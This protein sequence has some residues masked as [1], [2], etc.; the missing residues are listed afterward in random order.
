MKDLD[1]AAVLT[2]LALTVSGIAFLVSP[3]SRVL[4]NPDRLSTKIL[5]QATLWTILAG[6]IAIVVFW[7]RQ[8]IAS[9][10]LR[11]FHWR[12][13]AFGLVLAAFG[14]YVIFPIR[15]W[16]L[17]ASGLPGFGEGVETFL[18]LPLWFRIVA[19]TTAGIVEETLF[20]GYALTRL[21]ALLG[22]YWWAAAI[23]VPTFALLHWPTWGP[24][25]VLT[26]VIGG[27]VL[28]AIFI[29]TRDLLAMI[30]AHVIADAMGLIIAPTF[31]RWW[32]SPQ[33][34]FQ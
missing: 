12:S 14:M 17:R 25:P 15:M 22:S 21:G 1:V 30:I 8:P 20:H 3:A 31:S 11:P 27:V 7:E 18:A 23:V 24:G 4:G 13:I 16:A 10:W 26:F 19:V 33:A 6:V 9:L 32:E 34:S 29:L 28:T 2:G 5:E